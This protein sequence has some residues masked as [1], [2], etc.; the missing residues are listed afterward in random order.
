MHYNI[1]HPCK[2]NNNAVFDLFFCIY[3][4]FPFLCRHDSFVLDGDIDKYVL[5]VGNDSECFALNK[6]FVSTPFWVKPCFHLVTV[7][8]NDIFT[9]FSHIK[10][11][12]DVQYFS[13]FSLAH[14]NAHLSARSWYSHPLYFCFSIVFNAHQNTEPQ[15]TVCQVSNDTSGNQKKK[16]N[17]LFFSTGCDNFSRFQFQ[18][19]CVSSRSFSCSRF[20]MLRNCY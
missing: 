15:Q 4:F 3:A 18:T 7:W 17:V 13:T 8:V 12:W 5:I 16:D 6:T 11:S 10:D 20:S 19:S 9:V 14:S 2:I 1:W